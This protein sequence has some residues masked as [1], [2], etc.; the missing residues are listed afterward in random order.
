MLDETLCAEKL[1]AQMAK[2]FGLEEGA[3]GQWYGKVG[4]TNESKFRASFT[5]VHDAALAPYRAAIAGG[6]WRRICPQANGMKNTSWGAGDDVPKFKKGVKGRYSPFWA[7]LFDRVF[8]NF[9]GFDKAF[10]KASSSWEAQIGDE[11]VSQ[12]LLV[13]ANPATLG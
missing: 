3:P 4:F 11:Q 8:G 12:C 9:Q 13:S 1:D 6:N 10:A 7:V 2:I 5:N